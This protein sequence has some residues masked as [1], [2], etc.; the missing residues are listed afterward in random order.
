MRTW[1]FMVVVFS[2]GLLLSNSPFAFADEDYPLPA[3]PPPPVFKPVKGQTALETLRD[4]K[5]EWLKTHIR[6]L[7]KQI[8]SFKRKKEN[9]DEDKDALDKAIKKFTEAKDADQKDVDALSGKTALDPSKDT[10]AGDH[11]KLIK[12]NVEAWIKTLD[13]QR[14]AAAKKSDNNDMTKKPTKKKHSKTLLRKLKK[15]QRSCSSDCVG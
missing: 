11:A 12:K 7:E 2:I 5:V 8:K 10:T 9:P 4:L 15:N 1:H 3:P 13:A 14:E 6:E